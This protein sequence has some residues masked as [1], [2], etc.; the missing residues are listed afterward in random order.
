[1]SQEKSIPLSQRKLDVFFVVMFSF[2]AFSSFC[3]DALAGLDV[4]HGGST[5]G[6][7]NEWYIRAAG[8]DFMAEGPLFS[9]INTGIS[10]FVYGPFYLVLVAA[11]VRGWNGVRLPAI[12]YVG[13]MVHGYTEFMWW[14]YV[15]SPPRVP[16]VYW[17]F[18]APYA[19]MPLLLLARMWRAAPF[20]TAPLA[21][22]TGV[23]PS[24]AAVA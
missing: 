6:K 12:L 10:A 13:A 20:S 23:H 11:F 5:L 19:I 3:S 17:A 8:D 14:E 7:M 22:S 24:R 16:A 18:N 9:R 21:K 15:Y 2:F 4:V 1:M